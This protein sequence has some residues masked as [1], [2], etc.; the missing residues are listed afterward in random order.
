VSVSKVLSGHYNKDTAFVVDDYPYG[1][2]LRCK[3]RYWLEVNGKGTRFWSQTT[4]PKRTNDWD[5]AN[6]PK[7]STY[8][9]AGA[10]YLDEENHTHWDGF[11]PYDCSKAR[12][13]LS[14]YGEGLTEGEKD[15][16]GKLADAYDRREKAKALNPT[17]DDLAKMNEAY[18][19][20][21]I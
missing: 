6:T 2:R 3:I 11:S 12:A 7:A 20:E 15:L 18:S 5:T 9:V 17:A 14:T 1:F 19:K 21:S 4:N 8:C 13:F 16:I 10:M